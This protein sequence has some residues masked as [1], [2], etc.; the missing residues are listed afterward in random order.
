MRI[1]IIL[2]L[3]LLAAAPLGGAERKQSGPETQGTPSKI[4]TERSETVARSRSTSRI[5]TIYAGEKYYRERGVWKNIDLAPRSD[6]RYG[7]VQAVNSGRYIYRFDPHDYKKGSRFEHGNYYV[8]YVPSGDWTGRSV[9][10]KHESRGVKVTVI[11]ERRAGLSVCW[12]VE[13]N[14]E[15]VL[16]EGGVVFFG[17]GRSEAFRI[18]RPE[19]WDSAGQEVPVTVT[20]ENGILSLRLEPMEE[21][22]WPVYLDPTTTVGNID[23][24][25]GYMCAA[26]GTYS[27]ARDSTSASYPEHADIAAWVGQLHD[28]SV[29][30]VHRTSLVF[31]TSV[32]PADAIIDSAKVMMVT[33]YDGTQQ[34]FDLTLVAAT[35]SGSWS[36]EWFNDIA[37]WIPGEPYQAIPLSNAVNSALCHTVGDTCRFT[38]NTAGLDSIRRDGET[39]FMLMSA[40]DINNTPPPWGYQ[41]RLGFDDDSPRLVAWYRVPVEAPLDFTMTPLDSATIACSWSDMSDNEQQFLIIDAADSTVIR[42]LPA[43]ATMD[44]VRGL[45]MN[46]LHAWAVMADSAGVRACSNPDTAWTLLNPPSAHQVKI[47]PL[48]SDTLQVAVAAPPNAVAGL[49]GMEVAAISG[50]DA[51]GS[52]WR[53]GIFEHRDGGLN[54]DSA[55]IYKARYRNGGGEPTAWSPEIRY[56]M[57]GRNTLISSLPGDIHDDYA[58]DF[59]PGVRDSTVIR[60]GWSESGRRFDGF[61]SFRLPWDA[62]AGG[63]DSLF[64]SLTRTGEASEFA[65][66]ARLFLIPEPDLAPVETLDL[67]TLGAT[68]EYVEWTIISGEGRKRSPNLRTLYRLWQDLNGANGFHHGFGV[69]LEASVQENGVRAA[70]LDASNPSWSNDT[71][72]AVYYTPG[73]AD[74]LL[75]GPSAFSLDVLGPD[76]IQA[77]WEDGASGEFGYLL[78][79]LAD[80]TRVAG[81]DTLPANAEAVGVGGL[82]PNTVYQWFVQAVTPKQKTSSSGAGARTAARTPGIPF[83]TPGG[84]GMLRFAIDPRDNPPHTEFAVQDSLSGWFVDSD[85]SPLILR[86][87][88]SGEWS[89]RTFAG[90]GGASGDSLTGLSPNTPFG[91][92]VKAR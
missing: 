37:G 1:I 78:L 80:S 11:L 22:V 88:P 23:N 42:V 59:G 40:D 64:L 10:V 67:A 91:L 9:Q 33:M 14:A 69:R 13:A 86:P 54:P 27:G 30:R 25:T 46:T 76:S 7:F 72:L 79:N 45:S 55:Y 75:G 66:P 53:E 43:N 35:F 18:P 3:A 21:T 77:S 38:L 83:V 58:V 61:F 41:R 90:W 47:R 31:D 12:S 71:E 56:G 82:T 17:E 16:R 62:R 50:P 5:A 92:R 65:A 6:S 51:T 26:S 85:S 49:T 89:W 29:Y 19:A 52:G 74:T 28:G 24:K 39:K 81:T 34:E 60:V 63:V 44:T 15:A 20:L 4:L 32:I 84:T 8:T 57:Q 36:K 73:A 68:G 70:F 87:G 2:F 48:S